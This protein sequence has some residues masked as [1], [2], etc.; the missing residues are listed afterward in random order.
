[1]N[2]KFD[3]FGRSEAN[4]YF[5]STVHHTVSLIA[6]V[7]LFEAEAIFIDARIAKEGE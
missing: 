4:Y 2:G 7:R 1:M 5:T 6:L 3:R